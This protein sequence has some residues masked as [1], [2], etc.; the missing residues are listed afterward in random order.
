M[1]MWTFVLQDGQGRQFYAYARMYGWKEEKSYGS[2]RWTSEPRYCPYKD[3]TY[4]Q[5]R[6]EEKLGSKFDLSQYRQEKGRRLDCEIWEDYIFTCTK[7]NVGEIAEILTD[8]YFAETEFSNW[9]CLCCPVNDERGEEIFVYE[10]GVI[11]KELQHQEKDIIEQTV[12]DYILQELNVQTGETTIL[13]NDIVEVR[14]ANSMG[15]QRH[16][17][18]THGKLSL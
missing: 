5:I 13:Y 15:I 4:G 9:S 17:D 10:R 12:Y 16:S 8:M 3:D 7:D 14:K 1:H 2:F 18:R 11:T 6:I